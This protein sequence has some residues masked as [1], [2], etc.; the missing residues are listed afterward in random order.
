MTNEPGKIQASDNMQEHPADDGLDHKIRAYQIW[1]E[2]GQPEGRHR[3]HWARA[4]AEILAC[5]PGT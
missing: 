5:E 4:K 1:M 2:E 3:D